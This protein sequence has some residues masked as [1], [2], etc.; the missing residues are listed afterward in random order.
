MLKKFEEVRKSIIASCYITSNPLGAK[1][2]GF[3][4]EEKIEF[5]G[6]TPQLFNDLIVGTYEIELIKENYQKEILT[7]NLSSSESNTINIKLRIKKTP[8]YKKRWIMVAGGGVVLASLIT[9][10]SGKDRTKSSL[11]PLDL[12]L[13]PERPQ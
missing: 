10:I 11:K 12:P 6:K 9:I 2:I 5:Y 1:I 8:L 13:P 3:C 4:P 7:V